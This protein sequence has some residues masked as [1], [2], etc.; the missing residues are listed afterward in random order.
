[1]RPLVRQDIG[2]HT[3][4]AY[5]SPPCAKVV[6]AYRQVRSSGWLGG[7][8]RSVPHRVHTVPGSLRLG[9]ASTTPRQRHSLYPIASGL[10]AMGVTVTRTGKQEATTAKQARIPAAC[11]GGSQGR[12]KRFAHVA[13]RDDKG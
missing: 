4:P 2:C 7:Q 1:M 10:Y 11:P 5:L 13:P 6:R 3:D 12:H 8:V 9:L